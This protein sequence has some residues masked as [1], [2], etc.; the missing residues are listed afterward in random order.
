MFYDKD[1]EPVRMLSGQYGYLYENGNTICLDRDGRKM[2]V[3]GYFLAH[4]FISVL[5]GGVLLIILI[6]FAGPKLNRLL[7]V[8]YLAFIIYMTFLLR[9][10]GRGISDF[11]L[12]PNLYLILTDR[13]ILNNVWLFIPL[14]EVLYQVFRDRKVVIIP[15]FLSLL[16][17]T[18]QY[19]LDVGRFELS[20]FIAN[21]IGG[22]LGI[23]LGYLLLPWVK[24][25]K[26]AYGRK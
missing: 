21:C 18:L 19:S 6:T 26:A 3:P 14:G 25:V 7:F 10:T 5:A 20:D 23:I 11:N 9:E 24:R 16:I 17:E 13:E 1:G 4:S 8:L 15:V 22:I 12:P 2:F